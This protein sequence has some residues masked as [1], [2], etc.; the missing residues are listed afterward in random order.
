M[1]PF[2]EE[3]KKPLSLSELSMQVYYLCSIS[4][5]EVAT[6]KLHLLK[7]EVLRR[8]NCIQKLPQTEETSALLQKYN[9]LLKQIEGEAI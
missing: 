7:A 6:K 2:L 5:E 8:R 4:K 3:L 9:Q 1:Y